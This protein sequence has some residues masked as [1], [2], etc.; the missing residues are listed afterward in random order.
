MGR[1]DKVLMQALEVISAH[2]KM[3]SEEGKEDQDIVFLLFSYVIFFFFFFFFFALVI[4]RLPKVTYAIV[5]CH[6]CLC[7][8]LK[9]T[10]LI[11][12]C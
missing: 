7:H 5:H 8:V 2:A 3:R 6:L 1:E 10:V 4:W 11:R 9:A 12:V